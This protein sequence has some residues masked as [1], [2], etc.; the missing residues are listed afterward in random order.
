MD[1]RRSLWSEHDSTWVKTNLLKQLE[2]SDPPYYVCIHERDFKPGK[3][4]ITNIIECISKSYKTIFVLSNHFVSSEWCHYEFFFAHH[5]VF[6]EKKD[7][8]ILLLLEPIPTNSIPDRFCKLR[9]LMNKNTYLE[10]PHD[11][12][13]QSM[14]WKRLKAVL[15]QEVKAPS[16]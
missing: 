1:S 7:S 10:W 14:F 3:P 6:D 5:Q 8:L 16:Q 9:K 12:A 4:I 13:R 2:E 15:N 11:E